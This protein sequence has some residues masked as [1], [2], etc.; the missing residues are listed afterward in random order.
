MSG[1]SFYNPYLKSKQSTL[2]RSKTFIYC[3]TVVLKAV[4]LSSCE[5]C[6]EVC[7]VRGHSGKIKYKY[8]GHK[9]IFKSLHYFRI[10]LRDDSIYSLWQG[11]LHFFSL[12]ATFQMTRSKWSTYMCVCLYIHRVYFIQLHTSICVDMCYGTI[13]FNTLIQYIDLP[14]VPLRS[15]GQLRSTYW[16]LLVYGSM[17]YSIL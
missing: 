5:M 11:C 17:V 2:V 8:V 13:Q 1:V 16:A 6:Q 4:L 9:H 14:A 7:S 10:I 12:W 3:S 15:T